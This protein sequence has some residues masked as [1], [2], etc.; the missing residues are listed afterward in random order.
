MSILLQRAMMQ[1]VAAAASGIEFVGS[2]VLE[3][4]V[5]GGTETV[6]IPT[7]LTN[8]L[9]LVTS[10]SEGTGNTPPDGGTGWTSLYGATDNVSRAAWYKFA[11]G[12]PP[13]SFDIA[14]AASGDANKIAMIVT[15]WRGID[16][17][18][19]LD[20]AIPTEG[21]VTGNVLAAPTIVPVTDGALIVT[22]NAYDDIPGA[23]TAFPSLTNAS[24]RFEE[25]SGVTNAGTTHGFG[26]YILDTAASTSPGDW[27]MS[28]H[29][30]EPHRTNTI[31][32]RPA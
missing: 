22:T 27:D 7:C 14:R 31:A 30:N 15:V 29:A 5:G 21:A 28:A 20:V 2:N 26:A 16:T 18:T 13:T 17:G 8:D 4:G 19:P 6:S 11:G 9:I 32:F 3:I 1:Q 23:V 10:T 25:T 12:T 24:W